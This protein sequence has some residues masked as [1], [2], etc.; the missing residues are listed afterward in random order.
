[1]K[2]NGTGRYE[3]GRR[4]YNER[5]GWSRFNALFGQDAT[6]K[7]SS[8]YWSPTRDPMDLGTV[9]DGAG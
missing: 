8:H 2:V 9:L 6:S 5:I 3:Q 1:M 7:V 4:P